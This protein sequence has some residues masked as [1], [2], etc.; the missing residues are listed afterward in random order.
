MPHRQFV[1]YS[2]SH[3]T[4]HIQLHNISYN[5]LYNTSNFNCLSAAAAEQPA[6]PCC[7]AGAHRNQPHTAPSASSRLNTRL[8][9]PRN[10]TCYITSSVICLVVL[11]Y[12]TKHIAWYVAFNTAYYV[13]I[14]VYNIDIASNITVVDYNMHDI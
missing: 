5:W 6:C 7:C 12:I 13:I 9:H 1:C 8:Y 4:C 3:I 2:I 10:L 11:C 14:V